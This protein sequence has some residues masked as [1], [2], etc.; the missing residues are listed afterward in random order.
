MKATLVK[1]LGAL[2]KRLAQATIW[3]YRPGIVAI[4]GSAGKTSAKLAVGAVLSAERSVRYARGNFNNELGVPL[5]ILGDYEKIKGVFFWPRV[6]LRAFW[7]LV[8]T[9]D[10][11]D[12]LILE[13]GVDHPGDM[14]YLIGI[15][16]PNVSI[17]TGIGNIPPHVEFFKDPETLAREKVRIIECLPE[18]GYAVLNADNELTMDYRDRTRANVLTYGFD[19][20]ANVQLSGFEYFFR[21]S[22]PQGIKFNVSYGGT[23]VPIE[24]DGAFGRPQ[25]YA[26]GAAFAVGFIFG[27]TFQKMIS[28]LRR[29]RPAEHRLS[30]QPGMK[31]ETYVIDDS[32]NASPLSMAAALETLNALPAKRRVAVLGD[33]LE[34]GKYAIPAHEALGAQV[35]KA[36]NVLITVGTRAKFIAESARKAGLKR[37]N[38]YSFDDAEAAIP[39]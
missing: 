25:A 19:K 26:V 15:A 35:A 20:N 16:R 11:P 24:L 13:Y 39:T 36:A 12:I 33:M 27:M 7:N 10:Y 28:A 32:Y 38:I 34:L 29:Y 8:A 2:L 21:G 1:I 18:G 37:A 14:K 23:T 5:A 30:L 3:R 17:V 6:I 22:E 31:P 9:V 4:T